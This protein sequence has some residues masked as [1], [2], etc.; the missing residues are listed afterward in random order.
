MRLAALCVV[1]GVVLAGC[2]AG[3]GGTTVTPV[4][5][6]DPERT[7]GATAVFAPGVS[8]NGVFGPGVLAGAHM[9]HLRSQSFTLASNRTTVF[10]N[11]SLRSQL[12]VT[13]ALAQDRTYHARVTTAGPEAPLLLGEPPAAAEFWSNRFTY[14]RAFGLDRQNRTYNEFVPQGGHVGTWQY[15]TRTAAFGGGTGNAG[16]T[17]E[18]L[19]GSVS[20]TVVERETVNGTTRYRLRATE[21]SGTAFAPEEATAVGNLT[22]VAVVENTGLVRSARYRYD[23]TVD[24]QRVTVERAFRYAGVGTTEVTRPAWYDRATS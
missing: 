20:V 19:F 2:G 14:V 18:D 4:E 5:V 15:W 24:G 3:G 22:L 8:A 17:I 16:K 6:S 12:N 9:E 7:V 11:G 21:R 23:A 10:E 13:V 1:L